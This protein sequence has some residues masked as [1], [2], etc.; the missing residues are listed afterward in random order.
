MTNLFQDRFP[1]IKPQISLERV[2]NIWTVGVQVA[3]GLEFIHSHK[4]V[5]RD[6]K[7]ENG[8]THILK[9]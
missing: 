6:V 2:R 1:G 3:R 9:S 4:I 7:P 5:H 8:I